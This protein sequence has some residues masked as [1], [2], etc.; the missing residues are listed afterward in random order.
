MCVWKTG[1]QQLWSP[2]DGDDPVDVLM[3]C[4]YSD[5]T[6]HIMLDILGLTIR[7]L[8]KQSNMQNSKCGSVDIR[9]NV[10]CFNVSYK[11]GTYSM[12]PAEC[13]H[14]LNCWHPG[15]TRHGPCF[16]FSP[17]EILVRI[18][19]V[20][21]LGSRRVSVSINDKLCNQRHL[22]SRRHTSTA[23]PGPSVGARD[24][25]WQ[26]SALVISIVSSS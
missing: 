24:T 21:Q 26:E 15:D 20:C 25:G 8:Y 6:N 13:S 19:R 22:W 7:I 3:Q 16:K 12:W 1:S 4:W 18:R 5:T 23:D 2:C 11:T 9:C 17:W 10:V 14:D